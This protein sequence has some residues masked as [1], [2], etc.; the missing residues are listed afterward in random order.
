MLILSSDQ[1]FQINSYIKKNYKVLSYCTHLVFNNIVAF[2]NAV[3]YSIHLVAM[4]VSNAI[5]LRLS[6]FFLPREMMKI[7][8]RSAQ[9]RRLV[10]LYKKLALILF[11]NCHVNIMFLT[12]LS[13]FSSLEEDHLCHHIIRTTKMT[14]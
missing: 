9:V 14:I 11:T 2:P 5:I 7:S 8:E 12:T 3:I 1:M 13:N 6:Y 10:V 4:K